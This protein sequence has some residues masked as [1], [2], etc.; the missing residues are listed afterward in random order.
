MK[1]KF[2][3]IKKFFFSFAVLIWAVLASFSMFSFNLLPAYSASNVENPNFSNNMSENT[4]TPSSPS[5]YTFVDSNFKSVS[6][7]PQSTTAN[8]PKIT[9]GVVNIEEKG[10]T[11]PSSDQDNFALMISSEKDGSSYSVKYGYTSTSFSLNTGSYYKIAVDIY[12]DKAEGLA[13]LYLVDENN[14][15]FE[16]YEHVGKSN[17]WTTYM[18]LVE[19]DQFTS[20]NLKLAMFLDGNGSVLFDSVN[21]K[22]LSKQQLTTE[23]NIY[24]SSCKVVEPKT[25]NYISSVTFSRSNMKMAFANSSSTSNNIDDSDNFFNSAIQIINS[26]ETYSQYETNDDCFT[27]EPN[28]VYKLSISAKTLNLSGSA[29]LRLVQTGEVDEDGNPKYDTSN[30]H[31]I[32][33]TGNTSSTLNNGYQRYTFIINSH[34]LKTTTFKLVVSL[35]DEDNATSGSI[36]LTGAVLTKATYK[37]FED[38]STGSSTQKINIAS[39]TVDVSS[40]IKALTLSNGS[41]NS[42]KTTDTTKTYPATPANWT[43]SLGTNNQ[44]YGVVNTKAE[45]FAKFTSNNTFTSSAINPGNPNGAESN[46]VLMMYNSVTDTLSYTSEIDK[47]LDANSYHR[48]SLKVLTQHSTLNIYLVATIDSKEVVLSSLKNVTTAGL[49]K[50]VDLYV[51]TGL[52]NLTVG[53]KVEMKSTGY[54]FAYVDD[55]TFDYAPRTSGVLGQP[56]SEEFDKI[57]NTTY[58]N[59]A[60]LTNL[61]ATD[62]STAYAPADHFNST[63]NENV[64]FGILNA[65]DEIQIKKVLKGFNQNYQT[66][67]LVENK[68]ILAIHTINYVKEQFT[69]NIGYRFESNKYYLLTIKVYTQNLASEADKFGLGLSLSNYDEKFENIN[70]E[71]ETENGWKTYSFYIN[72]T[73][74]ATSYLTIDFGTDT[75]NLTGDAFIGDIVVREIEQSEFITE[76]TDT[77]K[78]LSTPAKD[79][80]DDDSNDD[81]DNSTSNKN[82]SAWF[83]AIPTVLTFLAI[84]IAVVGVSLRKV[85]IK[86]PVKKTKNAYDRNSKQSQQ[87]YMRKA[88]TMREERLRELEKQLETLQAERL[89]YEEQ[90]KKDLS[91][92]R[93]LKIKRAPATEIAKLEKDMKMNQKH[94]AQIGA[95]VRWVENEIEQTKTDEYLR[96]TVKKL[97][98]VK[99]NEQE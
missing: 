99:Q 25:D 71:N 38:A 98:S 30:D 29:S 75:A 20:Y 68:N 46:N 79:D 77:I 50:D 48:F 32:S 1:S 70:T 37:N 63:E 96:Q 58:V 73:D 36:S 85:K 72:P 89:T 7:N 44:L 23:K 97:A 76:S 82:N 17:N 24:S 95:N 67:N 49:W 10:Y 14:K 2:S 22:E 8:Q 55:A 19:T 51:N 59:K 39:K 13:S 45:E 81:S 33:I 92:L 35:G 57:Q 62:S 18:F 60:D 69:A 40:D 94:S 27:F 34:P 78:V 86:K 80:S 93:Q 6:Y 43:V 26:P 12:V 87:I 88:T 84:G 65:D 74:T 21:V 52:R 47:S 3:T 11:K 54:G 41:F 91:S 90:Y 31:T 4:N 5:S 9:A 61:T 64:K 42:V 83:I 28:R 56:T 53:V 66:F 15:A 16:S